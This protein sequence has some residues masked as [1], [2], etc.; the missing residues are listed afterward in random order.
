MIL[1]ADRHEALIEEIED[2]KDRLSVYEAEGLTME[3]GKVRA[4]L[5]L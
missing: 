2:L 1:S 3:L 5:G 4:E